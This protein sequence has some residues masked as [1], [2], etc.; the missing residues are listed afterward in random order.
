[1]LNDGL[2]FTLSHNNRLG[3]LFQWQDEASHFSGRGLAGLPA[4][5]ALIATVSMSSRLFSDSGKPQVP[6]VR[7]LVVLVKSRGSDRGWF[8]LGGAF[9]LYEVLDTL[10]VLLGHAF[11]A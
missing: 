11:H 10:G 8:W 7:K 3:N 2:R 5:L 4:S 6:E 1:M 9:L